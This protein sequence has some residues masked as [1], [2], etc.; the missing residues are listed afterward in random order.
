MNNKQKVRSG[1]TLIEL[2]VVVLIIGILAAVAVPQYQF[3]VLKSRFVQAKIM[4][5]ALARAQE[6]YYLANGEYAPHISQLDIDIPA[7][8]QEEHL[9]DTINTRYFSWGSCWVGAGDEH[10]ERVACGLNEGV[11]L[12]K[13]LEHANFSLKGK[14]Q[15]RGL[16]ADLNSLQNKLCKQESG[17]SAPSYSSSEENRTDWRY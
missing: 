11:T 12:Y 7:S 17:L 16:N 4:V 8:E 3:A 2:L 1:F 13:Y 5:S 9:N 15:C 10:G 14:F 6:V